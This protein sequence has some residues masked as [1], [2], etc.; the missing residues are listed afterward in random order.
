MELV[1]IWIVDGNQH[2]SISG[3]LWR[4]P[5]AWGL[6]LVDLAKHIANAYAQHGEDR[7]AMLKRILAGVLAEIESPTDEPGPVEQAEPSK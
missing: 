5:A 1:R 4:D 2:V 7:E 3:N 6:M